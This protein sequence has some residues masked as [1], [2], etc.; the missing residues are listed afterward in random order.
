MKIE[1]KIK[2]VTLDESDIS[3]ICEYYRIAS[4]AQYLTNTYNIP[5]DKAEELAE[6]VR[7]LMDKYDL[8]EEQAICEIIKGWKNC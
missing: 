7:N 5:E 4:T 8:G 1:Y 3:Q 2:G 6:R